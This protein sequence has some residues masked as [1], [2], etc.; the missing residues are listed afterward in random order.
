M[1]NYTKIKRRIV[2]GA[3][4]GV[5]FLAVISR[6]GIMSEEQLIER[7]AAASSLAENDVLS[8]IRALEM[9]IV[10]ATMNGIT[11][12]L[13]QM[14]DFTPYLRAKAMDTLE[15]VDVSTIKKVK[16]NF[17]P[18]S[19][20]KAKLKSSGFEYRDPAPKGLQVPVVN[21]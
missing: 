13:D 4:P 14:G 15:E 18:N 8:A 17:N 9:E 20:F 6:N 1:F 12:K 16:I 21:P 5:K 11:V 2:T 19:R 7:V 3:T 10:N